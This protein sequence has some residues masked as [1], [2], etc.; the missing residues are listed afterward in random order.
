MRTFLLSCLL[1]ITLVASA[2]QLR[3]AEEAPFSKA[4]PF[5][6][7]NIRI[8]FDPASSLMLGRATLM[9]PPQRELQLFFSDLQNVRIE[10][11]EAGR[12][13]NYPGNIPQNI[14]PNRDN[15][16]VLGPAAQA[17]TLSMSWQL[18]APPPGLS[19]NLITPQG[20]TLSGFWHPAAEE[21][22]LFSLVAELP[23]GFSGVTEADEIKVETD[24][25]QQILRAAAPHPLRAVH[26][27]AGPYTMLTRTV[28]NVTLYSYF[29]SEDE[30]LAPSCLDRAVEYIQRYEDLIGPFPYKRY[31]IVENRL[32]T[33]YGMPGF[34]LL[35]QSVVRLPFIKDTS[36]GHEILHSWF[37]NAVDS[38]EWGNWCEGLTALLADQSSAEEKRQ[39]AMYRKN[40]LLR[41]HA[42]VGRDNDLAVLDFRNTGDSRPMSRTMRAIGY[43]KTG[44][45]F[46]S[47][48][49]EI[50]DEPF[51]AALR[52][53]YANRRYSD[54]GWSDLENAFTVAS[55]RDLSF[56]F[57]QWLSR[58]DIPSFTVEQVGMKQQGGGTEISFHIVQHTDKP[59][60][61]RLPVSIG[62]QRETIRETLLINAADQ[63]A[64]ITVPSLPTEMT[65]DPEYDVMRTLKEKER[66]P[67]WMQFM[68]A[69]QKTAV[70]P[71]NKK[72]LALYLPL[73]T[74]LERWG[75]RIVRP[76]E[77]KNSTLSQGSFLFLGSSSHSRELFGTPER[78][79]TGFRLDVRKNPLNQEQVMVLLSSAS[80]EETRAALPKLGHYGKYSRLVFQQGEIKEQQ[81]APSDN[82]I[83]L[84]LLKPPVGIPVAQVQ[85]FSAIIDD[86]SRS[87]VI[88]A[89]ET[90]TDYGIH[91]LQLQIIQ[92]LRGRLDQEGRSQDLVIGMEMFPRASQPAL[93]GYINGAIPTEKDFLRL[94]AYYES[95]GYD[96]RMYRDV[97]N[98][99]KAHRLPIIALNL[100]KNIAGTVFTT[101]STDALTPEQ[102]REAASERD[103]DPVGYRE[104]LVRAHAL[105][106]E[107]KETEEGDFNGF[108]QAQ[109][110]RDETMAESIV[111][112]LQARPEKK[113]VVLAG[114]GH[115]YK[116]SAVPFRVAR[117][118]KCRQSVLIA[119]NGQVTGKEKGSQADY[120]MF[121]EDVALPPAGKIGVLLN[122]EKKTES[123][124]S[125]VEIVDIS[126]LSKAD[127]A[128]LE[129]GDVI[130]A[131]DDTRIATI[132]DLKTALLD[133]KPGETVQL[134]IVRKDKVMDIKV[135]LS[136]METEAV[137]PPGH[138]KK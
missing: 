30:Y 102:R 57:S 107:T 21:K 112:Y 100:K 77:L 92:A 16:L 122:E 109:A 103:L 90:H 40:Q 131:V 8:S 78:Q 120:L 125:R 126:P 48:R 49:K 86:I 35:G 123:Q 98:Y 95:W 75:C 79:D 39:G 37:G 124:P 134:N 85:D 76:E 115:V 53:V 68:G 116:D 26:F 111:D 83:R 19:G 88:Y 87:R 13:N 74:E 118:M 38:G 121:T 136:D 93:D 55:G 128:G 70:L 29:F 73:M 101:G 127:E 33:G 114:T 28:N 4:S 64:V 67:V 20:I 99:A 133:K 71:D 63:E 119:D 129:K 11:T 94:S 10:I 2:A 91:L 31:S 27:A 117:R 1:L 47:L 89:G 17:R 108:L 50:G 7:Q 138:P 45:L 41:Y 32:P 61:F 104:R 66:P 105:H 52:Q 65:V 25:I 44:M 59:Y 6:R 62:T 96:Y 9:L 23:P 56:F 46:H 113:M 106:K 69:Q 3:S 82:G 14:V 51:F 135:E 80:A 84:P 5:L 15:T 58:P 18:T 97:I 36:L 43:D 34:T 72:T 137:M 81:V 132:S 22:M 24:G 54:A 42:Y 110:L 12:E 130:L 60:S